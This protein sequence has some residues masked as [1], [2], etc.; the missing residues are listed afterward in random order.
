LLVLNQSTICKPLNPRELN[1]YK[2]TPEEIE[3]FIPKFK[4]KLSNRL[5]TSLHYIYFSYCV[6]HDG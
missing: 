2:N 5:V 4:G 1:F 6:T 3:R